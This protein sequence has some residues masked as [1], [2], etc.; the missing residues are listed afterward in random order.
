[1]TALVNSLIPITFLLLAIGA[2]TYRQRRK[3]QLL[4]AFFRAME[5]KDMEKAKALAKAYGVYKS[6]GD[7]DMRDVK[8]QGIKK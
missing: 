7:L 3:K 4:D 8:E 1:M 5:E 2:Y 6:Q